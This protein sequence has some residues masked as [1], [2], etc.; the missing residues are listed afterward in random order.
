[1]KNEGSSINTKDTKIKLPTP[2]SES[3]IWYF[4]FR[5][6]LYVSLNLY[7]DE[8]TYYYNNYE[9]MMRDLSRQANFPDVE[10]ISSG[11]AHFRPDG[12]LIPNQK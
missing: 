9:T 5:R 12:R 11:E 8:V 6:L 1:M 7:T 3:G 4:T 10:I 2:K